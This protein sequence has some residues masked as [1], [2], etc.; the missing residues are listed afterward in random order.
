M[1]LGGTGLVGKD[2]G[3]VSGMMLV[4]VGSFG[5][6]SSSSDVRRFVGKVSGGGAVVVE[7]EVVE[8]RSEGGAISGGLGKDFP[9]GEFDDLKVNDGCVGA[10][11]S[12]DSGGGTISGVG[13]ESQPKTD[14]TRIHLRICWCLVRCLFIYRKGISGIGHFMNMISNG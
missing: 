13:G 14:K 3:G 9:V 6:G 4:G 7:R 11:I 10:S 5:L 8:A 2:G 1:G 12:V